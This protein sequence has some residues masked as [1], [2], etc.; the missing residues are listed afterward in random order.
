MQHVTVS[1]SKLG[2]VTCKPEPIQIYRDDQLIRLQL[3]D[4]AAWGNQGDSVPPVKSPVEVDPDPTK[5]PGSA[6]MYDAATNTYVLDGSNPLQRGAPAET[7][8]MYI[9]AHHTLTGKGQRHDPDVE[10]QSQP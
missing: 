6:A 1:V 7:Y 5:W 4:D 3:D 2:N 8:K 9:T 10:N